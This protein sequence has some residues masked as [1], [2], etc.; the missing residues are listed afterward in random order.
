MFKYLREKESRLKVKIRR[1]ENALDADPVDIVTLSHLAII[2]EGLVN[3]YIRVKVWPKLLLVNVYD[4][5]KPSANVKK[6]NRQS[7]KEKEIFRQNKYWSQVCADV[8][9]SQPRFPQNMRVSK[10][11]ALQRQVINVIMRLLCRNPE[12]H[13]YQGFHDVAVT[14]VLVTGEDLAFA[15][16]EQIS[17]HQMRDFME[18]DFEK[19]GQMLGLIHAIMEVDDPELEEFLKRSGAGDIFALSWVITWFS[20]VINDPDSIFRIFDFFLGT[21]PLMPVYFGTALVIAHRN[22]LLSNVECECGAVHNFLCLLPL[23][24][25]NLEQLIK[26]AHDLFMK[27]PPNTLELDGRKYHKESSVVISHDEFMENLAKQRPD[28]VLRQRSQSALIA[29]NV[30]NRHHLQ[31]ED[32]SSYQG[33]FFRLTRW[34]VTASVGTMALLLASTAKKWM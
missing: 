25:P 24:I 19:T 33:M 10:R 26:E 15:L 28:D 20:H 32:H 4:I 27:Y 12:L 18:Q 22:E 23:N 7:L 3:N 9:R 5:F 21:H 6:R 34:A 14:L 11:I 29:A 31:H 17:L 13:Y 30:K 2:R 16:L 8:N 1:I